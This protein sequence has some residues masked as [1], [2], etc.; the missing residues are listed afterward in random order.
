MEAILI[1]GGLLALGAIVVILGVSVPTYMQNIS[2]Q[3]IAAYASNAGFTGDDLVTAVAI[4]FA[5]SSGNPD[6]HG[7]LSLPG[8]GSYG[9]WQIYSQAHP[10][11][12]PDFTQL[13]D[14]Q[15]N[16]SAAF[17]VYLDAG[18]SFKPW[19]TYNNGSYRNYLSKAQEAVG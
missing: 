11:Y 13:F 10:E 19:S 12:G 3:S 16:A 18:N 2:A 15:T 6:A 7:D 5:E 17:Q 14:P 1:F 4:A 8:S 9:L